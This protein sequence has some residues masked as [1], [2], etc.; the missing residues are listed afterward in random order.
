MESSTKADCK[1][2]FK[3]GK[4]EKAVFVDSSKNT[5]ELFDTLKKQFKSEYKFVKLEYAEFITFGLYVEM[6]KVSEEKYLDPNFEYFLFV[7]S[8]KKKQKKF[9]KNRSF[10]F[11]K[12]KS[13][14]MKKNYN[15]MRLDTIPEKVKEEN[16]D[17]E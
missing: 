2:Y 10:E 11:G 14:Q 8:V 3:G 9:K 12:N 16:E 6:I 7:K 5:K 1:V 17:V 4:E 13:S 15:C